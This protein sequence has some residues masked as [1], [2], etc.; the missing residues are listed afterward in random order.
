MQMKNSYFSSLSLA[1]KLSHLM[2]GITVT[3]GLI[4]SVAFIASMFLLSRNYFVP[5]NVNAVVKILSEDSVFMTLTG[6]ARR[7]EQT[8]QAA[9]EYSQLKALAIYN[10]DGELHASYIKSPSDS[11]VPAYAPKEIFAEDQYLARA[12]SAPG[13]EYTLFI[14][15]DPTLPPI[16]FISMSA[17]ALVLL[18]GFVLV[19]SLFVRQVNR[20]IT[21]PILHLIRITSRVSNDEHYRIRARAFYDDEIG[22]LAQ[23]F[24]LMLSRISTR[25]QQLQEEKAYER[26]LLDE[27]QRS[28][29]KL[30]QEIKVRHQAERQLTRFQCYLNNI[31]DS[32]PS[33]LVTVNDQYL[34]QQSNTEA[35]RL[36][37]LSHHEM[38]ERPVM[39]VMPFL[40][41]CLPAIDQTLKHQQAQRIEKQAL[42]IDGRDSYVDL[43]I[44]PLSGDDVPEAVIRIDDITQ[45]L[46]LEDVVVQSEKMMSVGGLAAGM[47]HEINNPL[48]AVVQGVQNIR[49]RVSEQLPANRKVAR[50]YNLELHEL[51]AYFEQR[52]V[53]R[54]L[55]NIQD[56][57]VRAQEIVSNML[58]FSRQ[59]EPELAMVKVRDLLQKS[60]NIAAADLNWQSEFDFMRIRVDMDLEPG[61]P[62]LPCLAN[63]MQQVLL[64]LLK[65]AAHAINQRQD[66]SEPGRI[67]ISARQRREHIEI[68]LSDNGCG[69]TETVCQRIFEPFYTTKDTGVGTGLGLSVSYFIITTHHKGRISVVSAPEKGTEFTICLPLSVENVV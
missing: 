39:E 35:D 3:L 65:N 19:T 62:P 25:D 23:A 57:G 40:Q 32:M 20:F 52:G 63:E 66:K 1:S 58:Q 49:R 2:I 34:V 26:R 24:N 50:E 18:V 17:S 28:N 67:R 43:I 37:G 53:N 33:A 41:A 46:K 6:N 38:A 13:L 12:E 68:V 48:G 15:A 64:N 51:N 60:V 21:R 29:Q 61:L 54:F 4:A 55:D 5:A 59:Q 10:P 7:A 42:T 69:M 22:S 14:Q 36:A 27:M 47:A 31:I 8:L 56:A 45:R 16:F 11:A 30:A 9:S 44:Y